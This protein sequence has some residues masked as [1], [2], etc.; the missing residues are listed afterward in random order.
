MNI[1]FV[2]TMARLRSKTASDLFQS[3]TNPCKYAGTDSEA[4]IKIT[5]ELMD[6]ADKI[7]CMEI[8]HRG[9]LR[10]KFKGY[11]PKMTVWDIPDIYEHM[12]DGLVSKL[13]IKYKKLRGEQNGTAV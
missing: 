6:W 2:C 8:H 5:K 7:V 1:L 4:D 11:S 12:D 13:K 3:V 10:R 9:K